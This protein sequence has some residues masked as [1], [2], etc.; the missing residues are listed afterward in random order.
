MSIRKDMLPR[1]I[2]SSDQ[3]NADTSEP[4]VW[5]KMPND[6]YIDKIDT[7]GGEMG[8]KAN[9]NLLVSSVPSPWARIHMTRHA[10]GKTGSDD[11]RMLMKI[12]DFMRD[13]WRGF[14]A[15]Y[16]LYDSY[17]EVTEPIDLTSKD[18]NSLDGNFDI[19]SIFTEMLFNDAPLWKYE[20]GGHDTPKI[21]FIYY[22]EGTN[23]QLVGG[24]SPYSILFT[25]INYKIAQDEKHIY[26]VTKDG[27]FCDPANKNFERFYKEGESQYDKTHFDNLKKLYSFLFNV[28]KNLEAYRNELKGI[29]EGEQKDGS[30]A[31]ETAF[32]V[33]KDGILNWTHEV[34]AILGDEA[35]KSTDLPV[36]FPPSLKGPIGQL[37]SI[38]SVYY[39]YNNT[40]NTQQSD[41]GGQ[42][43]VVDVE[44]LFIASQYLAIWK[45]DATEDYDEQGKL[46]P[47]KQMDYRRSAVYFLEVKDVEGKSWFVAPPLSEYA[48]D[49]IFKE[50]FKFIIEGAENSKVKLSAKKNG[51]KIDVFLEAHIDGRETPTNIL[52]RTFTTVKP[53]PGKVFVWP[54]FC[55]EKWTKYYYYSEFPSNA[56]DV[57]MIPV[58]EEIDNIETEDKNAFSYLVKYPD[59]ATSGDH[60]YEIIR[61][62]HPLKRIEIRKRI[63]SNMEKLGYL[64]IRKVDHRP[65]YGEPQAMVKQEFSSPLKAT[66]GFDF[67]STNSCAYY[68]IENTSG[69]DIKPIPFANHRLSIIGFD[70]KAGETA[71]HDELLFISNEEP[72]NKN[73][74]IKSWLHEHNEK[75]INSTNVGKDEELVGGVPV[76]ETNIHVKSMDAYEIMTQAGR[77]RYNMKWLVDEVGK[78]RKQAF[79]KMVWVHICAD[80]FEKGYYP[81]RLNW[82]YP[83]AMG[84]RDMQALKAI[85]R[86]LPEPC[87]SY[88]LKK[89]H[90]QS[91]TEA[92]AVCSYF[93]NQ[94]ISPEDYNMFLGVDIGGSTSDILIFGLNRGKVQAIPQPLVQ[95]QFV[96]APIV[97]T[98][99]RSLPVGPFYVAINGQQSGPFTGQ[100]LMD[101]KNQGLFSADQLVFKI[102]MTNWTPAGQVPELS[103]IFEPSIP[104][105]P[106]VSGIP[107]IPDIPP[108]S[109]SM[110]PPPIQT[111]PNVQ[112]FV[113]INGQPSPSPFTAQQMLDM[114]N[115]GQ[116]NQQ[117][118]VWTQG[119]AAWTPA[120]QVAE[121]SFLFAAPVGMPPL[122]QTLNQAP[123]SLGNATSNEADSGKPFRL[124]TQCSVRMAAGMFF[125]AI[126]SS[127]KFRNCIQQF[128][129]T[130][131][132]QIKVEGIKDMEKDPTSAPYYLN[133]IFDQLRGDGDFTKF[134]T[135]LQHDVPFVFALPAYITGAIM[136]YAGML[137]RK[138][139]IIQQLKNVVEVNFR[140]FG[141]GGRLFEWLF[142]AFEHD[143][144]S[145]YLRAC[146]KVG[147]KD[148]SINQALDRDDK[149]RIKL[150]FDNVEKDGVKRPDFGQSKKSENKSEVAY[151]LVAQRNDIAG[152]TPEIDKYNLDDEL[153][154]A[155]EKNDAR[156]QEVVGEIGVVV[157]GRAVDE[158]D[159]VDD[160][161]YKS[162]GSVSM[163]REFQNFEDFMKVFAQFLSDVYPHAANLRQRASEVK[164]VKNFINKDSEY[165]KY[166]DT[167]KH[168]DSDSYRMPVFVASALYYL[169]EVLL[170][171]VFKE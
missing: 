125:N 69:D 83:S 84:T 51:N 133:N 126:I 36:H 134:Y 2:G 53:E 152:I 110:T 149:E 8:S 48:I 139:I 4:N 72:V 90:I 168:G 124:F 78:K 150:I 104:G 40:F 3:K 89:D 159:Y 19:I 26:W 10:I 107:P 42:G 66:V 71:E 11:S 151:G 101:M 99:Q 31:Y 143:Q 79:V 16:I 155:E 113:A 45:D 74:Q 50:Q 80:L 21:Q 153:E 14:V 41:S 28:Q 116:L 44:Q 96:Q 33:L 61:A 7:T 75:F 114:K 77:L 62:S 24:T 25:G 136:A 27:K 119:M 6:Q 148:K 30:K 95:P 162:I 105:I 1:I 120:G 140:Y 108:I 144:I 85:F 86:G 39:W 145:A 100:Q 23:R 115:A 22:K 118:Q 132:T 18:I 121:L 38:K 160:N 70:N 5:R 169:Q 63:G 102:G 165:Q 12:Y 47:F 137:M 35:Q 81:D 15:A 106:P 103:P 73:G 9:F 29:W 56:P 43:E 92:E 55:S 156:K 166:I 17:F 154:K 49:I 123:P 58:F 98:Q 109:G 20:K 94:D 146:F 130:R 82:S 128:H 111:L 65:G 76:N 54:N 157:N 129:D 117:T 88:K 91:F 122:N 164:N 170:K 67:G 57:Q 93:L 161:F 138:T 135:Y 158:L 171:E 127:K 97:Q 52:N 32:D 112:Y 59:T 64:N 34:E 131:Q 60:V 142:F 163:P 46:L 37:L 68:Q 147:L 167:I 87:P 141:K 13:E